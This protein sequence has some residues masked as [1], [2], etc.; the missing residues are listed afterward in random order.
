M[1]QSFILVIILV[2]ISSVIVILVRIEGRK[3]NTRIEN[4]DLNADDFE[5]I[6]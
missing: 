1:S 3:E 4:D 2:V 5:I 6:E